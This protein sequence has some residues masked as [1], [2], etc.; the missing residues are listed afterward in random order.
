M[1]K[2]TSL[3]DVPSDWRA[4]PLRSF[5][6]GLQFHM[7]ASVD[8]D[9]GKLTNLARRITRSFQP[10]DE[11]VLIIT[12]T[13]VFPSLENLSLINI[14]RKGLDVDSPISETPVHIFSKNDLEVLFS[15]I[16]L[17]FY[18]FFDFFVFPSNKQVIFE[19]SHNE[20]IK[21]FS[22]NETQM[23]NF[24]TA[25]EPMQ[26]SGMSLWQLTGESK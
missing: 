22:G 14:F 1:I 19:G 9:C 18:N 10:Y 7:E 24:V 2:F 4:E 23:R 15:V 25:I 21:F 8:S 6:T 20:V 17:C 16:C 11:T 3:A 13:G 12:T 26:L 5:E